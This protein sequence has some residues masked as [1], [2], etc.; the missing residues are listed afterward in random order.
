MLDTK[1]LTRFGPMFQIER[2]GGRFVL[3]ALAVPEARFAEVTAQVNA[4]PEV[5]HNPPR[6]PPQHV[7]RARHRDAE[8]IDDAIAASR[9]P[10]AC[11]CSPF[12]SAGSSLDMRLQA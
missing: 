2:L 7:V 4:F 6:A 11:R 1:V 3:A 8:G 5:A 9:R 10:P 12:P